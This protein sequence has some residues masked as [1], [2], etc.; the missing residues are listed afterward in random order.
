MQSFP[1]T[2]NLPKDLPL[3][4]VHNKDRILRQLLMS[5]IEAITGRHLVVY[6]ANCLTNEGSISGNDDVPFAELI[7][8]YANK[9]VDLLI[10]TNGGATDATEK[11]CGF[12][13]LTTPDLRVIVPRRAKSN[14]TV[15]ALCG[16]EILMGP[17]SELGPI[18][19]SIGGVPAEFIVKAKDK[20]HPVEY[21]YAQVARKQTR[22]LAK[23]LLSTGMMSGFN[24]QEINKTIETLA[25]KDVYHSHGSSIDAQEAKRINLVVTY[26]DPNNELWQRIWLLRCMYEFDANARRI[27]KLYEN[28]DFSANITASPPVAVTKQ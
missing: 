6:F 23:H 5:D 11:L 7:T 27:A 4:W 22:K 16:Q 24:E 15:I 1:R 9:P 10:E 8:P 14:G 19:P 26:H 21:E 2:V 13:R 17:Q 18:D 12:L 28:I 3:T 25:T 20:W